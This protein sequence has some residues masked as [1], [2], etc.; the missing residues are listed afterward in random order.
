[1]T[2][3]LDVVTPDEV[4]ARA[5][6]AAAPDREAEDVARAIVEDVRVRGLAALREHAERLGDLP[7]G[8]E[9]FVERPALE[10]AADALTSTQRALLE[11]T[12][13]RIER[14][15][16]AQVEAVRGF[17]YATEWGRCGE[18][19]APVARAGCYAPGGRHPLPSSVLMTVVAARVAGV[20]EIVVASPRPAIVTLAAA[21]VAGADRVLC[22]GGAQA[23]AAL[24]LGVDG[25]PR[26]D[27]IAG[28]G[29][30]YVTAAKR[31]L[32]GEVGI[33]MLAG[34]SE[35]LVVADAS[36]DP[37][38]VAADLL[39]QAEHDPLARPM[40]IAV[41]AG[42]AERVERALREQLATLPTAEVA[43]AAL[44]RGFACTTDR[45]TAAALAAA[46]APE[47]LELSVADPVAWA[48]EFATAGALFLGHGAAEVLGDYGAGPN[49]VLPTGG[50]A[51]FQ[52]PLSP[53]TFL[54]AR[55]Y[56]AAHEDHGGPSAPARAALATLATDAADLARLE[57]LEAHARA[58]ERR[59]RTLRGA[60]PSGSEQEPRRPSG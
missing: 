38:T 54:V 50:S 37:A 14:F 20:R 11:R 12:A 45:A 26:V 32:V 34:P 18:R 60:A 44:A 1:M 8:A 55:P 24:A 39:A 58:A 31:L 22:A 2:R 35:V 29:N 59:G 28:P 46:L 27:V 4:R 36:A 42:L 19:F 47:H 30:R 9:P 7:R 13:A 3:L 17:E 6:R 10:R 48:D 41:A 52:S 23:V 49:H 21:A 43:R 25:L 16:R 53:R 51:R 57:G 15:A 5:R 56:M 40:L 33:D